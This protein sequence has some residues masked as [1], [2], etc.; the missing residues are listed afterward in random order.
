[1]DK[2]KEL[3]LLND[4]T[5][6][7]NQYNELPIQHPSELSELSHHIHGI[8]LLLCARILRYISPDLFPTYNLNMGNKEMDS[9]EQLR[10]LQTII[11]E[12][13]KKKICK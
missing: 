12:D 10:Y 8:Q 1:M 2:P 6:F 13:L 5:N 11:P 4:I 7:W 3:E 9:E